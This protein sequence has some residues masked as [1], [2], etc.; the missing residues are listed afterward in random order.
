MKNLLNPKT[1]ETAKVTFTL[2]WWGIVVEAKVKYYE[3]DNIRTCET[4]DEKV[5]ASGNEDAGDTGFWGGGADN[6]LH[7]LWFLKKVDEDGNQMIDI[8]KQYLGYDYDDWL[9]KPEGQAGNPIYAYDWF[10]FYTTDGGYA[11]GW[12]DWEGFLEK[13]PGAKDRSYYDCNGGFYLNFRYYIPGLG[14]WTPSVFDTVGIVDGFTRV[15]YTLELEADYPSGGETPITVMAGVDVVNVKYAIYEG[16]LTATQIGYKVDG[17][18]AGTE[19]LT[20]EVSEFVEGETEDGVFNFAVVNAAPEKTGA[21][22]IVAV[23][24]GNKLDKD[25]KVTGTEAQNS[26][27]LVFNHIAAEDV[28]KY[29]VDV[30]VGTEIVPARYGEYKSSEAF[31]FFVLGNGVTAANVGVFTT[32]DYTEDKE[33]IDAAVKNGAEGEALSA[34]ALA[35]VNR[36]GGYYSVVKG[37]KALTSYTVVVWATNGDA[38]TIVTSEWKTEGLPFELIGTGTYL[39]C[40]AFFSGDDPGLELY[41]NPNVAN[42]YVLENVFYGV[43]LSFTVDPETGVI[44][45]P[46]TYSGYTHGTYGPVYVLNCVN[47]FSE[48]DVAELGE[49]VIKPSYLDKETGVYNFN[50]VYAVAAG[51]F[52]FGFE[53][54]TLDAAEAGASSVKLASANVT[55]SGRSFEVPARFVHVERDAQAKDVPVRVSYD[56]K[57]KETTVSTHRDAPTSARTL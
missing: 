50:V 1:S 52:G 21:W 32:A 28:E 11:G 23:A 34:A 51:F 53:T 37:L 15:D 30:Q 6:H 10:H 31:G 22:T 16:E 38:D 35:E 17:I 20:G 12:P 41:L 33:A 36:P 7:F 3:V 14:G 29:A 18:I 19:A 48:E 49:D 4:Y 55:K 27:S 56:Y 5:I 26:A 54:F 44:D 42:T 39:Y 13:N 47:Y 2:G 57:V 43:D 40:G 8:P 24:Y 45:F 9:A 46:T 25:G